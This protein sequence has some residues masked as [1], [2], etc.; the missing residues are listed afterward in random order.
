MAVLEHKTGVDYE[1]FTDASRQTLVEH[2]TP[3]QTGVRRRPT[4]QKVGGSGRRDQTEL[5]R[6]QTI[7]AK[8]RSTVQLVGDVLFGGLLVIT[9]SRELII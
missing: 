2:T 7:V 5:V 1:G 6:R 4:L 8:S 3:T 9:E